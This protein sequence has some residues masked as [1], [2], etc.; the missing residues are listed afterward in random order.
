MNPVAARL[1]V[2]GP[3]L[4]APPPSAEA[5]PTD[6]AKGSA[7]TASTPP[8]PDAKEDAP[9]K[10]W[11][12]SRE[13]NERLTLGSAELVEEIHG[14]ALRLLAGEDQRESR[15]DAKAQGL[16]VTAG[17]SLTAASTFGGVLLQHPEYL[18]SV[19]TS[20]A[21]AVVGIYGFGLLAGLVASLF[22]VLGLLVKNTFRT[23]DEHDALS[24]D[25]LAIA[26]A[27]KDAAA[28][29]AYRR[30][31]SLHYWRMWQR[32]FTV[33]ERKARTIKVGQACFI[34]FLVALMVLGTAMAYT[35]LD[36]VTVS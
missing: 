7:R 31:M 35:A 4:A 22:A 10:P 27:E 11:L 19:G 26:D 24:A 9:R 32:N 34:A 16:L 15:I 5:A 3:D 20:G 29:T 30:Y 1:D 33:L 14:L 28:R 36:R 13:L 6:A 2:G 12:T 18:A 17:L 8:T 21:K 25:A 23:V